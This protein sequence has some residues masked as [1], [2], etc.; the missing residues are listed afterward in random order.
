MGFFGKPRKREVAETPANTR[1]P[2]ENTSIPLQS[3]ILFDFVVP[4]SSAF[5]Q[6][7]SK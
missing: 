7:L 1:I 3:F 5:L 2:D 6:A 4:R